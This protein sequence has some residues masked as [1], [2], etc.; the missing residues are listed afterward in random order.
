[1]KN[2]HSIFAILCDL[3]SVN[4]HELGM[5]L[6]TVFLTFNIAI[7]VTKASWNNNFILSAKKSNFFA[8]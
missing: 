5:I 4:K 6:Q 8:N 7:N 1:M 3:E 2:T